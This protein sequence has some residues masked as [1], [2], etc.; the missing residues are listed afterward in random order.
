MSSE[1]HKLVKQSHKSNFNYIQY[2]QIK[3]VLSQVSTLLSYLVLNLHLILLKVN[4]IIPF[5]ITYY[6]IL[7]LCHQIFLTYVASYSVFTNIFYRCYHKICPLIHNQLKI[8]SYKFS[9]GRLHLLGSF[10]AYLYYTVMSIYLLFP[11]RFPLWSRMLN[12]KHTPQ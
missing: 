2:L 5:L 11:V 3:G 12:N 1:S 6:F 9:S 8:C 10:F 7:Y 4:K